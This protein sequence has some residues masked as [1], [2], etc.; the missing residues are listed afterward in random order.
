[1]DWRVF[2]VVFSTV[3]F[4]ELGDKTQLATVLFAAE[5]TASK[6]LV[7]SGAAL[8]LVLTSGLGVLF[9]ESLT[10]VVHPKFLHY[11]AGAGFIVI[12]FLTLLKA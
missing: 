8:A 2:L 3:F 12:G 5:R 11:L 9:G 7:F 6:W 4:A 10:H 1:M